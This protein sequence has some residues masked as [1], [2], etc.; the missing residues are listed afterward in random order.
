M[1]ATLFDWRDLKD[2]NMSIILGCLSDPVYLH[3][4]KLRDSYILNY[5]RVLENE[6]KATDSELYIYLD[7]ASHRNYYDYKYN[8]SN[9]LKNVFITKYDINKLYMNR[10]LRIE[11][12]N[13]AFKYEE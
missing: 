8:K 5:S 9:T 3:R 1:I 6:L 10:L 12:G 13:I 2:K 11:G 7:L 4:Q